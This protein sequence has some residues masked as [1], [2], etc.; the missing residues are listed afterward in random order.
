MHTRSG[1]PQNVPRGQTLLLPPRRVL[2]RIASECATRRRARR[3]R[4]VQVRASGAARSRC[5]RTLSGYLVQAVETRAWVR[6]IE[7]GCVVHH[8]DSVAT[9]RSR[10]DVSARATLVECVFESLRPLLRLLCI[11]LVA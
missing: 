7:R 2:S 3:R 1:S 4:R 6:E 9:A 10:Y 5:G 8:F 11:A